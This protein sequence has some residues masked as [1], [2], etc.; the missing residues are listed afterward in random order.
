MLYLHIR[1]KLGIRIAS[2]DELCTMYTNQCLDQLVKGRSNL[3]K[4]LKFESWECSGT[5][6]ESLTP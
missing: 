3:T 5:C 2:F 4:G 6:W 1:Y